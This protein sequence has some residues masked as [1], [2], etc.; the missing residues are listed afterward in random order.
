MVCEVKEVIEVQQNF[1]GVWVL[2]IP[3]GTLHIKFVEGPVRKNR[4]TQKGKLRNILGVT[5]RYDSVGLAPT[6]PPNLWSNREQVET[7]VHHNWIGIEIV[8]IEVDEKWSEK[9]WTQ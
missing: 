3:K 1:L 9:R 8:H 6:K 4:S 5:K 7:N 2:R